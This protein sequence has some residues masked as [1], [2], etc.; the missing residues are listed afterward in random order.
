MLAH[1]I[2]GLAR[3]TGRVRVRESFGTDDGFEMQAI[4]RELDALRYNVLGGGNVDAETMAAETAQR[5]DELHAVAPGEPAVE[6]PVASRS[7]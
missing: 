1:A 7:K 6:P 2:E 3:L 5:E 4:E